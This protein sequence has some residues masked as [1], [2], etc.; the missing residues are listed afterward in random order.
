MKL[1]AC[2]IFDSA[3][4]T[5]SPPF[6]VRSLGLALRD[7]RKE[8]SNPQSRISESAT[9]YT[10]FVVGEFNDESGFFDPLPAPRRVVSAHEILSMEFKDA[11]A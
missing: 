3:V 9:D 4:N 5:Y 2:S 1:T 8:A 10:L 11:S 6:F 7:F